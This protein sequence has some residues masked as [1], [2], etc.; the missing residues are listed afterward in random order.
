MC[1]ITPMYHKYQYRHMEN[2]K[3]FMRHIKLISMNRR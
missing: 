3:R 2:F 1:T